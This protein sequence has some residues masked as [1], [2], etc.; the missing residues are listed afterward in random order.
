MTHSI[1]SWFSVK[2]DP[3]LDSGINLGDTAFQYTLKDLE[4]EDS[5][6]ANQ[7]SDPSMPV[8]YRYRLK[9]SRIREQM[10]IQEA[11]II[12]SKEN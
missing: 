2:L 3:L 5:C 12:S 1:D 4:G 9:L 7:L 6:M 8:Y 11:T 10:Q